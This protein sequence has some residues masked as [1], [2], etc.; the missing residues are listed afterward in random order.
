MK[1]YLKLKE[2]STRNRFINWGRYTYELSELYEYEN[3]LVDTAIEEVDN[4]VEDEDILDLHLLEL[5]ELQ[6]VNLQV[7]LLQQE[8]FE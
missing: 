7:Y 1:D 3:E 4:T 5:Q 2:L 6:I 8:I